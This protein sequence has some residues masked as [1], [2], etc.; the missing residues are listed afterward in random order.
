MSTVQPEG[1][2]L[3]IPDQERSAFQRV[4]E[5]AVVEQMPQAENL[6]VLSI[7]CG[8]RASEA[9]AV[10]SVFPNADF[11]G[12]DS[13]ADNISQAHQAN[14]DLIRVRFERE[15]P[16]SR[17]AFGQVP[18][19]VVI[20]RKPPTAAN[21]PFPKIH[22]RAMDALKEDGVFV[23]TATTPKDLK[24]IK[25]ILEGYG[26]VEVSTHDLGEVD[27]HGERFVAVA[28]KVDVSAMNREATEEGVLATEQE[29]SF[30]DSLTPI[31]HLFI[32]ST[33][34]ISGQVISPHELLRE[35]FIAEGLDREQIEKTLLT[36]VYLQQNPAGVIEK[37]DMT[38]QYYGKKLQSSGIPIFL[39]PIMQRLRKLGYEVRI[40]PASIDA[41]T[42]RIVAKWDIFLVGKGEE[43]SW[44]Q[45]PDEITVD[46]ALEKYFTLQKS[47]A[48]NALVLSLK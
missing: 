1:V 33:P 4:L 19:D 46:P 22:P 47:D 16:L 15:N 8:P 38:R 48:S 20:F 41:Q 11:V 30:E 25:G 10:R 18:W 35:R 6:R 40:I 14:A 29:I 28:K 26:A 23:A 21:S 42:G 9:G 37:V 27:L 36:P 13:N 44:D 43:T 5:K 2:R 39:N 45:Y 32:G 3:P 34:F 31:E 12:M 17:N 24:R 7:N